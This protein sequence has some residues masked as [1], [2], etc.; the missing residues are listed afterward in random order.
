VFYRAGKT[1]ALQGLGL[2]KLARVPK[3]LK[4]YR[5]A[6]QALES[7]ESAFHGTRSPASMSGILESGA[8][9]ASPGGQYGP[10]SY[11]WK[12]FPRRTNF[13]RPTDEGIIAAVKRVEES[14]KL[15][16]RSVA[17]GELEPTQAIR[18]FKG[19]GKKG[20]DPFPLT[21]KDTA[22]A[23]RTPAREQ[24]FREHRL[25]AIDPQI[26]NRAKADLKAS[27]L[28]TEGLGITA[29]DIHTPSIKELRNIIRSKTQPS[30]KKKP[31]DFAE[32]YYDE[33]I[34]PLLPIAAQ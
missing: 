33:I 32:Q 30:W 11:W 27:R 13:N 18:L 34:E 16:L 19:P 26:F 25:R 8:I 4:Q 12:G 5:R 6:L 29:R 20:T 17:T 9:Q 24:A 10:G 31:E 2:T 22:I 28:V 14:H 7:G 21:P 23:K 15:P 1:A 3:L